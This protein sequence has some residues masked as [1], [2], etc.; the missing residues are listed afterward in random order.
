MRGFRAKDADRD[1]SVEL[2]EAAYVDGQIGD[3]DRELRVG[4]ALSAETLDEL[5]TL[6]RDLQSPV[7][8]VV[9][10]PTA[11]SRVPSA[12]R[13]AGGVLVGLVLFMLLVAAGVTGVVALAFFAS[14]G[15]DTA[16]STEVRSAPAVPEVSVDE[17]VAAPSFAMTAGQVR[18]FLRAYEEQF[19]TLDVHEA[20]FYPRRVGVMVPVRGSRPR[21]E[22]WSW[23]GEWRQDTEASRVTGPGG[24]VDLDTLD[25]R[26][27]FANIDTARKTLGVQRGKLT[28]VLVNRWFDDQA[29]VNI[30]IGNQFNESGYL[31][32]TPSGDVVRAFPYDG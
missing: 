28:H 13:G 16:T 31:R 6:T 27:L 19:G 25:V 24:V 17:E 12:S 23:T 4:R 10:P 20:G 1:R 2:I 26:R 22:R 29:A 18:T 8:G 11:A 21:M 9:V 15:T 32:T 5:E 7:A 14:S 3:A 30:Y